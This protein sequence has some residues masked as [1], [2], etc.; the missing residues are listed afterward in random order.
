M[1]SNEIVG[2]FLV[3]ITLP[4]VVLMVL[5]AFMLPWAMRENR[6]L[7]KELEEVEKPKESRRYDS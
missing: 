4:L 6:K 1:S 7:N 5:G 2:V 3:I